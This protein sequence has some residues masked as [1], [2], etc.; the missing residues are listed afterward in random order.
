MISHLKQISDSQWLVQTNEEHSKGVALLAEQFASEFGCS[1]WGRVLGELHDKGKEQSAFQKY[2]SYVSGYCTQY[3]PRENH[4]NVGALIAKQLYPKG[5]SDPLQYAIAGH[6]AGLADNGELRHLMEKSIP[7][8]VTIPS[9]TVP[10]MLPD[11]MMQYYD[12]KDLNHWYRMLF[13]CLVDAD[14]LDTESFMNPDDAAK[15]GTMPSLQTLA[16]K[17]EAYLQSIKERAPAS[18]VNDIRSRIQQ[19]CRVISAEQ[20][21]FFSLNVPTGGGKTLSSL[22]WAVQHALQYN[23]KRI[24]IVIP[25]TSIISQTAQILRTI[26]GEECV[27]EHDSQVDYSEDEQLDDKDNNKRTAMRLATE[28]WDYP[29]V[30]T[31]NVQLFESLFSNRPSR[32]RKLHNICNSV[33]ILDEIQ[34]LPVDYLQP[35][36]DSL[37]TYQKLF[38]VSVLFTTASMPAIKEDKAVEEEYRQYK[39][40][41]LYGIP[42]VRDIIP[43]EWQLQEALRRVELRFCDDSP[44]SYDEVAERMCRH[45]RVL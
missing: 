9:Q 33:M 26:F 32:C 10:L 34:T 18:H 23:K 24:I 19:R 14:Y 43:E 4:A 21:G 2:I 31:T 3:A 28:N 42:N 8:N 11:N 6:H 39:K 30:V 45:D 22:V 38:G 1:N 25:Y 29:I 36:V 44:M 16:P 37:Q 17:L 40:T 7:D 41:P 12:E 5:F 13:S 35:I 20:P 27:L 15:R